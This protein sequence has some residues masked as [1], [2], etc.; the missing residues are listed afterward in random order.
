VDR[1][2]NWD[3]YKT[4]TVVSGGD[5]ES[6]K[7]SNRRLRA[8][9][10]L[11][12]SSLS[13]IYVQTVSSLSIDCLCL[14]R[15]LSLSCLWTVPV[16]SADSLVLS[17]DSLVLSVDSPVLSVDSPVLSVDSPVCLSSQHSPMLGTTVSIQH[18]SYYCSYI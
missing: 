11:S 7:S 15:G 2:R 8:L 13:Y 1:R 6:N 10:C 5:F 12:I 3:S 4:V 16:L 18:V 9:S 17:V 14:V